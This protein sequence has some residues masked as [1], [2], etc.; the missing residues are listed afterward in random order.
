MK[1]KSIK[2]I[3]KLKN[4]K[5]ITCLTAY[6]I[7]MAKILDKHVDII[8]IGDSVGTVIYG[9]KNTQSV[10]LDMM[11]NHGKAVSNA[12][13]K[14]HTIIDMPYQ[15]YRNK[16]EA[17]INAKK[18]L[19]FT[20]CQSVKLEI[21]EKN[22]DIVKYL[23]AK[24]IR[25]VSHIGVKPQQ[26]KNFSKIKYVG[27]NEKE[28]E[29]LFN[30]ASKLQKFGSTLILLECV[31]EN[32]SKKISKYLKIP[33]IGIGASKE[34]DGQVLVTND[35]LGTEQNS[36]KPKFIKSYTKLSINIEKAIIKYCKDVETKKF[37]KKKN[38]Y[39]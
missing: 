19:N 38:T 5:K 25:V 39:N 28:K 26:F 16:K 6:S 23:T 7:S 29:N 10:T 21:D 8:L 9:M 30:L 32:L 18:L 20:K 2:Y 17:L 35:I 36:K 14:A 24:K 15:T 3:Q 33:T 13:K 34:C 22:V 4:I 12:T 37:P 1:R 31:E 11:M 27:K